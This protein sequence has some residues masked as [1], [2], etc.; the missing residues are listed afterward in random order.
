MHIDLQPSN[1]AWTWEQLRDGALAAEE[2]GFNAYW[3]WDHLSGS[4]M[5]GSAMLECWSLLGALGAV[6]KTIGIGPMVA[7]IQNRHS[8]VLANAAATVQCVSG[9]R[10]LLGLGCGGGPKSPYTAEHKTVGISLKATLTERHALL[11][12]TLDVLDA[13]WDADRS[14]KYDGFPRPLPHAPKRIIGVNS[15]ALA[16]LA[17]R[18][19]DG[20]NVRAN[21]EGAEFL[22]QTARSEAQ[23]R[24]CTD[25][26]TTVWAEF[27][28]ALLDPTH[29]NRNQWEHWGV[30]RLVLVA[31][32]PLDPNYVANLQLA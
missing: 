11:G 2:A 10:L 18:R 26:A 30:N 16:A 27:D 14:P 8:A 7:N 24:G 12:E 19:A 23:A 31:F 6:T 25:F 15:E 1:S 4:A 20:V 3:V 5:G 29:P 28:E 13:L 17:G 32:A 9:G 22:L 21:H